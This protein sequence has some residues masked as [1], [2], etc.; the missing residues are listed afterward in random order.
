MPIR[1]PS[2]VTIMVGVGVAG[3]RSD[4][5]GINALTLELNQ[6]PHGLDGFQL[7][8]TNNE[9]I[10]CG[11]YPCT[12]EHP[13]GQWI[14]KYLPALT[15]DTAH[16]TTLFD[17]TDTKIPPTPVP[18]RLNRP[19]AVHAHQMRIVC[20]RYNSG[21][22]QI[23]QDAAKPHLLPLMEDDWSAVTIDGLRAIASWATMFTMTQEFAHPK[24]AA[25]PPEHR[26]NFHRDYEP[27]IGWTIFI[28]RYS[29]EHPGRKNSAYNH[30]GFFICP[31]D[32]AELACN[33]SAS[34]PLR[35]TE[36]LHGGRIS[37]SS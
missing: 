5:L 18:G 19:G 22:M 11:G 35:Q 1:R 9:C 25:V 17:P 15:L 13:W 10:Y 16:F 28:G 7:M 36:G 14:Q 29:D 37:G 2:I 20:E 3:G 12:K 31:E 30:H 4:Y 34:A 26:D 27:P 23:R 33:C 32:V 6:Q 21:W 8:P 24:A